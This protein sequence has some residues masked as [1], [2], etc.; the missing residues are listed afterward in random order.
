M[1][2]FLLLHAVEKKLAISCHTKVQRAYLL[3]HHHH[4]SLFF[5]SHEVSGSQCSLLYSVLWPQQIHPVV[6]FQMVH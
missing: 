2:F 6:I 4:R 1:S 3:D 5:L